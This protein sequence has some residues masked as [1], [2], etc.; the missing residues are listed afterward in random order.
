MLLK[1][2][3][4]NGAVRGDVSNAALHRPVVMASGLVMAITNLQHFTEWPADAAIS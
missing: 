4:E 1:K 3:I 2:E